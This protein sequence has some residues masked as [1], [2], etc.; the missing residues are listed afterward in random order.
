[1]EPL[2]LEAVRGLMI[3]AQGLV[4]TPQPPAT[5]DDVL[6]VI[7][8]LH[9]LQIDSINVVARAP[10]FVLW[11]RL[12]AYDPNWLDELLEEGALFEFWA[13]A[14]SFIPIEDYPLYRVGSRWVEFLSP[15]AWIKKNPE[16]VERVLSRIRE[17]GTARS[18]DFERTDGEKND[19]WNHKDEKKA[20]EALFNAGVLMVRKREKFQRIYGLREDVYP[21]ADS[22]PKLTREQAHDQLALNAI[23]ALG[24]ATLDWVGSFY[25][26]KRADVKEALKRLERDGRV[27]P[28]KVEGW[29]TPCYVHPNNLARTQAA[30]AGDI[31][32][33]KTT[34][35]SPFDPVTSD[36]GR[37]RD[38]F[39][40]DYVIEF[41]FPADKRQYGYFSLPIL[42]DNRLVGRLD[43]KAHRKE[44]IFEVKS[45]H[46]EPDTVVDDVLVEAL[47]QTLRAC[48]AWHETPQVVVREATDPDLIDLLSD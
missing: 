33:S 5:K 22:L 17:A 35:L 21:E 8:H 2:S 20:L 3:A 7:R 14:M 28:V 26:F 6:A 47:R 27:I 31:P 19:W 1:M 42:H 13:R 45:L 30:A 39:N 46:L 15:E 24:V 12:G 9:A 25:R 48:A 38:L 29:K 44:G 32:R 18:A 4:D 40:F 41:Y 36:Y 10:Y 34:L 11:S 43:P 16:V 23:E 37:M